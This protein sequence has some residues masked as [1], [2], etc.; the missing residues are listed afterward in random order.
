MSS[1]ATPSGAASERA[2]ETYR[3]AWESKPVLRAIY[4]HLY[5]RIAMECTT[6]KSLEIGGGS[7][8]L[9]SLLPDVFSTDIVLS[10]WLDAVADAQRLPFATQSFDNIVM[11]DVLHHLGR[12]K[13]FFVE[14]ARVLR[15]GGR[16]VMVEPGITPIS[17][18]FFKLLHDEPV[19]LSVDPLSDAS[20][21]DE[22]D[23]WDANQ[24]I[25]TVLFGRDRTRFEAMFPELRVARVERLSLFAY[26][27]S[28][29]FKKWQLVPTR[30]VEPL[31]TLEDLAMPL[32]GRFMSYRLLVV[33]ERR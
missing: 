10:P 26:P 30:W 15:R 31:L 6:G 21:L 18:A 20:V 1:S 25:P 29:G 12:P 11:F 27:L 7:G 9:K 4:Q 17:W 24:A 22:T 8:N 33:I 28:G 19:R 14:A 3:A 13:L 16:V 5:R 32:L 23:P 2:P